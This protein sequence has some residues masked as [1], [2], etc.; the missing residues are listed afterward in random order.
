MSAPLI[1]DVIK[2]IKDTGW[3]NATLTSDFKAYNNNNSNQ[4][5]YR[6]IGK[7]VEICG[8]VSPTASISANE[9]KTIFTLPERI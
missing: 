3:I 2:K 7:I 4:P 9:T 8:V 1:F 6:K 5:C